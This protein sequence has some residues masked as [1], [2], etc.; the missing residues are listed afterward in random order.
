MATFA[1][2]TDAEQDRALAWI[3]A[4]MNAE[5]NTNFTV[6]QFVRKMMRD[7]FLPHVQRYREAQVIDVQKQYKSASDAVKSQVRVLLGVE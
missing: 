2:T 7:G 4:R 6:D 1:I 5:Q 3:V